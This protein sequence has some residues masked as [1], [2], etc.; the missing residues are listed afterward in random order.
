VVQRCERQTRQISAQ[1]SERRELTARTAR[2]VDYPGT[3]QHYHSTPSAGDQQPRAGPVG[4]MTA[5][6]KVT[7]PES[8]PSVAPGSSPSLPLDLGGILVPDV[9]LL[10]LRREM[11]LEYDDNGCLERARVGFRLGFR[12]WRVFNVGVDHYE[13]QSKTQL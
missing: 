1:C 7:E 3:V 4:N 6:A 11:E 10:L 13:P 2:E 9:R 5:Q 12:G 8:P